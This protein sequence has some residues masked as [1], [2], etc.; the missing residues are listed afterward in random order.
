MME[1]ISGGL[2][3][4]GLAYAENRGWLDREKVGFVVNVGMQAG[5]CGGLLYFIHKLSILFL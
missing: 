4:I 1:I 5:I 2:V 3:L